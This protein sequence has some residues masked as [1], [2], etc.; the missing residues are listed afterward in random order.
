MSERATKEVEGDAHLRASPAVRSVPR[1]AVAVHKATNI[2]YLY[3]RDPVDLGSPAFQRKST[4][5]SA[6]ISAFL[7]PERMQA[8]PAHHKP[9]D[10]QPPRPSQTLRQSSCTSARN[11]PSCPCRARPVDRGGI[12]PRRRNRR[13]ESPSR[14]IHRRRTSLSSG[15]GGRGCLW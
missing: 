9:H 10:F 3:R 4:L 8:R 15:I 11:L 13:N 14:P 12:K 2:V 6:S 7:H 5:R 1:W